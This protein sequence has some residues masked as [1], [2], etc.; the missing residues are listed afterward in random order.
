MRP[1]DIDTK[2]LE[3]EQLELASKLNLKDRIPPQKVKLVA[4]IDVTFTNIWTNPTTGISCITV[5]DIQ[6]FQLKEVVYA[7]KLIDFPYIPTFLAYRELPVIL[8]AYK[9]LKIKPDVFLVDG[10]GIIHPRKMGIASHF[11]V[12][13]DEVSIGVAKSKLVGDFKEPEN[14]RFAAKPVYINKELRGYV[15]RTR[16]NSKPLFISPGNN[17][18]VESSVKVAIRSI[19]NDYRLPEPIRV[20]HNLLQEYRRKILK[21]TKTEI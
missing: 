4:G 11:G 1:E 16:K 8:E 20:A 14:K 17:I 15:I 21:D 12:V 2:K 10:Q 7:Q 3:K 18:S 6:N 9:K 19:K 5:F 13:T